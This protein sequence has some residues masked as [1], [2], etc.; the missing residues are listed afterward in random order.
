MK[1]AKMS[2]GGGVAPKIIGAPPLR[3]SAT[4]RVGSA[5]LGASRYQ[6]SSNAE[7]APLHN[8]CQGVSQADAG[9]GVKLTGVVTP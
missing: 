2:E 6:V 9:A 1:A 3:V 4:Q 5:D 8:E 7:G